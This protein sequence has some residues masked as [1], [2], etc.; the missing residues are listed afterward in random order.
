MSAQCSISGRSKASDR[1]QR[2]RNAHLNKKE[3][4]LSVS[5]SLEQ[6]AGSALGSSCKK[7]DNEYAMHVIDFRGN[8]I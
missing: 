1:Q 8:F 4:G 5:V 2:E 3:G 6:K 7:L